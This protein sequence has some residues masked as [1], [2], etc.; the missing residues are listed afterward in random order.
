MSKMKFAKVALLVSISI[1]FIASAQMQ[2]SYAGRLEIVKLSSTLWSDLR[3]IE[4][5][6]LKAY[7][8]FYDGLTV[9]DLT[10]INSPRQIGQLELPLDGLKVDLNGDDALV[11]SKDSSLHLIDITIDSQPHLIN[12]FKLPDLPTD[13]KARG[14]CAY[15]TGKNTALLALNISDPTN[16]SLIGSCY[17][18][19]FHPLCLDLKGIVAYLTGMGGLKLVSV[20]LPQFPFLIGSSEEIPAASKISV[21][22]IDGITYAYLGNPAQFSIFDVSNPRDIPLL[23]TYYPKSTIVDISVSGD[24]TF[25][26]LNYQGLEILDITDRGSPSKVSSFALG[27]NPTGVFFYSDFL[28][29]TG[30]FDPTQIINV[31]HPDRPFA[32]GKW[33]LPGTCKDVAVNDGYAY[34]MCDHSGI[35]MLDVQNPQSPQEV[36]NL[37][38]PY[39]NNDVDIE[40]NFVYATSLLTGMQ[41]VDISDPAHP[42]IVERYQPE[43]YTYGVE[44][45]DGYAYLLNSENGI[46]IV[47]VQ[48]PL[49]LIPRGSAETPG[50][51]QKLLARGDYL[52]V[53]DQDTG[54]TIINI[55]DKD[56]PFLVKS[57]PLEGKCENVFSSEDLLFASCHGV[58]MKIYDLT[59]PETPAFQK[60]YPTT[61]RIEDLYVE[62][63]YAY[64]SMED[65]RVE[66]VDISSSPLL[67]ATYDLLDNPGNLIVKD[68]CIYLCDSRSFKILQF[69]P[70]SGK[71][72]V[73]PEKI[74]EL[75][76]SQFKVKSGR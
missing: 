15:I 54:I 72:G 33:I 5:S 62:G 18:D 41:V 32:S 40:G 30:L 3:D 69:T 19:N 66:V 21:N 55:S 28:F 22:E 20:L 68:D 73:K 58:G 38:L 57:I 56:N 11:I 64:L 76:N 42:E 8:I 61:E 6:Q 39:N 74:Q 24:H 49:G 60:L 7:C 23:F 51:A 9:T 46:Q 37:H 34:V 43:G 65:N 52:Y 17:V 13:I 48:N 35:H 10:H 26:V 29:V 36:S 75:K 12:S 45:W 47:D 4:F 31:F 2:L 59:D 70:L 25:L 27:D 63:Q 44:V 1:F 71:P 50:R 16:V 53:A 14:N 67:M